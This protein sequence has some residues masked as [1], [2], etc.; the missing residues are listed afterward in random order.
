MLEDMFGK[1]GVQ[2]DRGLEPNVVFRTQKITACFDLGLNQSNCRSIIYL[3]L[4][5]GTPFPQFKVEC[6]S[7]DQVIFWILFLLPARTL[8]FEFWGEG[9]WG[10]DC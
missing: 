10:A 7:Q 5:R 4:T 9:G 1:A 3:A 6:E 8:N 2:S